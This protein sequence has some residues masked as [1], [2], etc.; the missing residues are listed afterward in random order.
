MT[1]NWIAGFAMLSCLAAA[2]VNAADFSDPTWPCLQRKVENLSLGI[3]WPHPVNPVDLDGDARDL[4]DALALRRISL[5]E[6]DTLVAEFKAAHPDVTPDELGSIFTGVFNRLG[7]DRSNILGGIEKYSLK[8]LALSEKIDQTRLEMDELMKAAEPD[9]DKVDRL[10]EQLD[11]D[12]RIYRDR[13]ES[14]T[15][16]CE[17]PVLLEKRIY[18]IAQALLNHAPE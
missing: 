15:Y 9:F 5:E 3:M 12:E 1:Q 4:A 17:T 11:W 18:A 8:Q 14:L 6:A 13:K 10:E 2:P 16:V 7:K